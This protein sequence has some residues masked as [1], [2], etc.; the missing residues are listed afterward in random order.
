M[1]KI[2]LVHNR[3]VAG[4]ILIN[5]IDQGL[6]VEYLDEERKQDVYVTYNRKYFS[7][8]DVVTDT[9]TPGFIDLVPSD[10]VLLSRDSGVI[11]GHEAGGLITVLDIP[12]G[13]LAAPTITTAEQDQAAGGDP[14]DDYRVEITG[15]NFVSYNPDVSTVSLTDGTSTVELTSTD[16]T[17]G[18]GT[19]T[20]TSIV[21]PASVHGFATDGSE[22]ITEVTVTANG[23]S[24]TSAVAAI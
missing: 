12:T 14:T 15:T 23:N 21:I 9:T 4:A 16:I 7:G 20:A 1:S 2:R 13:A 8:L 11:A 6:P 22:D 5:D 24:A 3:T 17:V 19:F 10:K 18:G